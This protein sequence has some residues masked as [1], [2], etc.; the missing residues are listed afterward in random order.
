MTDSLSHF[1]LIVPPGFEKTAAGELRYWFPEAE[2]TEQSRG[3]IGFRAPLQTGLELNRVLKVPTRILLRMADFGCRDFP[4][5]FKKIKNFPWA[6]WLPKNSKVQ[7]EASTHQSR[8]KIKKRIESTTLEALEKSGFKPSNDE[9][10]FSIYVRI[11][12]D[13][14]FVSLDTS[15]EILHKRGYREYTPDAPLRENLAAAILLT[16]KEAFE[17][18][19]SV[20]AD[21]LIKPVVIDP[22]AGSGTFLI[23]AAQLYCESDRDY[24]FEKLNCAREPLK[25]QQ[26][27]SLSSGSI[28]SS[29]IFGKLGQPISEK[30]ISGLFGIE[31]DTKAIIAAR[32]AFENVSKKSKI[33]FGIE[34]ADVFAKLPANAEK[35]VSELQKASGKILVCNPPYGKRL[36][37]E[38]PFSV[39]YPRLFNRFEELFA[40]DI[41]SIILPQKVNLERLKIPSSWQ[42]Q[43][44]QTFSNGGFSVVLVTFERS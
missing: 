31:A 33:D 29:K 18:K 11:N 30:W 8:L 34:Q 37:I 2:I 21:D 13:V 42:I 20:A 39:Y 35:K 24:A 32:K 38:E 4:K 3:G 26:G 5:L 15:G 44:T 27:S 22:M 6:E 40:P 19:F 14:C 36:K 1:F 43:S 12:E 28:S 10:A 17:S 9:D 7:V 23:E 16:A 41:A 25:A